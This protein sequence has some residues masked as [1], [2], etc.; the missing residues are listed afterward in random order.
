MQ[1]ECYLLYHMTLADTMSLCI[2]WLYVIKGIRRAESSRPDPQSDEYAFH[3]LMHSRYTAEV[4]YN[5]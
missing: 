2:F 5:V 1:K 4:K 3:M